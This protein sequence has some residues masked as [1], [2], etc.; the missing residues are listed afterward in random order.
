MAIQCQQVRTVAIIAVLLGG[1]TLSFE[2]ASGAA[3]RGVKEGGLFHVAAPNGETYG[4]VDPGV[5]GIDVDF[6]RP[7]CGSLMAYPDK[8]LP[9]GLRLA[10][11]LAEAPPVVSRNG[12]TYTF[13]L[14]KD[15]RFSTG[16]PVLARDL[17][18]S[19]ERILTPALQSGVSGLFKDVVGARA[20][21][22]GRTKML[23]GAVAR[24]RTLT[25]RLVRP[26]PDLPARTIEVC[27]VPS[28]LPA[29]VEGAQAPIPS[30]APY[31]VAQYVP[32]ERLVL[33]RNR[34]YRGQRPRHV[35]RFLID[36]A[37]DPQDAADRVESGEVETVWGSPSELNP[38]L[39][40]LARLYGVNKSQFFVLPSLAGR[41]FFLNTSRPLFRHNAKLRQAVNFAVDRK[42]LVREF[43]PYAAT[44]TDQF[45]PPLMPGFRDV[46]IYPLDGPDLRKA[47]ALAAGRTR[48]GKAVLYIRSSPQDVAAAQVLRE[49]LK[50]IGLRIEIK[51]FPFPVLVQ[52]AG[53]PG[54]RFDLLLLGWVAAYKD[55]HEFIGLFGDEDPAHNYSRF[56]SP[57]YNRLLDRAG[58]LS[59]TARYRAYGNLDVRLARD[60]APA[61][62]YAVYTA[63]SF[64]SKNVGCVVMNPFLDLTA[65]CLQ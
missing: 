8:K 52:K 3:A 26:V 27:A 37:A 53:T 11:E 65:V 54:E 63:W 4:G 21:L 17:V 1:V 50:K 38:R 58:R 13:T 15:A 24:G 10:P 47:R 20:M 60:A 34:F 28:N 19:L 41:M 16:A 33:E 59:G 55:P 2:S 48:G 31:Y 46:R 25:L 29:G 62:P 36:V 39:P 30:A 64:V 43:G 56:S 9:E 35:D 12:K 57:A 5:V 18:H 22:S 45:L 49:N 14:R 40:A 32:G 23:R 7:A 44:A 51:Q 6:L 61:I 42:A